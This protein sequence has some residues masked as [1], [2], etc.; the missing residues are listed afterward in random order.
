[1]QA[2]FALLAEIVSGSEFEE[3]RENF[4]EDE[5]HDQFFELAGVESAFEEG[6]DRGN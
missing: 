3:V 4:P 2:I 5:D 1:M 6:K